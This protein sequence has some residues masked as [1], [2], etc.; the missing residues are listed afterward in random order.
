MFFYIVL[1]P[2]IWLHN[3]QWLADIFEKWSGVNRSATVH[4]SQ[5]SDGIIIHFELP[6]FVRLHNH[7]CL[8]ERVDKG[9]GVNRSSTLH[10][11]HS[12][13]GLWIHFVH[14]VHSRH[15]LADSWD[16]RSSV[17]TVTN[18]ATDCPFIY[19][20]NVTLPGRLF[21]QRR[22]PLAASASECSRWSCRSEGTCAICCLENRCEIQQLY[23]LIRGGDNC[24]LHFS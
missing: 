9:S 2:F 16:K 10:S 21:P 4:S 8:A 22:Q 5:S 14:F 24:Y 15:S 23:Y 1:P 6:P 7:S 3:C 12:N 13:D 18:Q 19:R 20:S 17:T 11:S